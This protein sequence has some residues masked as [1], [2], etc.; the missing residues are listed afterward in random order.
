MSLAGLFPVF[1]NALAHACNP[2]VSAGA[3]ERVI[4]SGI[5]PPTHVGRVTCS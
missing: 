5:A 3:R 4:A 1:D 2:A